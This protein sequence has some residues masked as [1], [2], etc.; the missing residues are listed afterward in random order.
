MLKLLRPLA[1]FAALAAPAW[2]DAPVGSRWEVVTDTLEYN[3]VKAS[4]QIPAELH[5]RNEGSAVD[6]AGLC[7]G[8]SLL[9]NGAYQGVPGMDQGKDSEWWRYLK[10]RPGGSYP[11]KLEADLK[12]LYPNEKWISWEGNVTDLIAEYTRKGYPVAATMN[13]GL[14]YYWS[15]IHH[16]VSVVHLDDKYACVVDNNNP[17]KGHWMAREDYDRR[18]VD[19]RVGWLFIWLRDPGAASTAT[20]TVLIVAVACVVCASAF[21]RRS[22]RGAT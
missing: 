11:G 9:I 18:F 22:I 7:V 2:A 15:P 21:K 10:S 1:L 14:L 16:M 3:G 12:K 17:G 5:I 20:T 19:G 4:V 8:S 13:T 6:G